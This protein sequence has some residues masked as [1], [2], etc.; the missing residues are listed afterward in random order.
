MKNTILVEYQGGGYE[1]CFWEWNYFL[2]SSGQFYNLHATGRKG[3][4]AMEAAREL[5]TAR[6][7]A[8]EAR[9][10]YEEDIAYR[11]DERFNDWTNAAEEAPPC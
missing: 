7:T 2:I 3:I 5:L 4:T 10:N 8:T 9:D 11:R 1:G 6:E